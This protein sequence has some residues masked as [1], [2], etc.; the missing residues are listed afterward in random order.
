MAFTWVSKQKRVAPSTRVE[1]SR[2]PATKT[3]CLQLTWLRTDEGGC[4]EEVYHLWHSLNGQPSDRVAKVCK[5]APPRLSL[6]L[7]SAC[8][9]HD[10]LR[11][12]VASF[13]NYLYMPPTKATSGPAIKG[14]LGPHLEER[15]QSSRAF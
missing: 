14:D 8:A 6:C 13:L 4:T 7:Y 9:Q 12:L 5:R 3:S 1:G 15:W 2:V 11:V 10:T